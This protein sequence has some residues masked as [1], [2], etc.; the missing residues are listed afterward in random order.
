[1]QEF[2]PAQR[3]VFRAVVLIAILIVLAM[4]GILRQNASV[5]Y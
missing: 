5:V 3:F 4:F 2:T 1:M